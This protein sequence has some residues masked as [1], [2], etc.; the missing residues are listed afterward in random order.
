MKGDT[1]IS[2]NVPENRGYIP[3]VVGHASTNDCIDHIFFD[4]GSSW[5]IRTNVA[6][7]MTIRFYKCIK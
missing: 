4:Y 6:Q 5:L 3:V 2:G 1:I 7:I